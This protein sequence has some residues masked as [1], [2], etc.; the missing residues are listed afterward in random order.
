VTGFDV[1]PDD[2]DLCAASVDAG[3]DGVVKAVGLQRSTNDS[4]G[5]FWGTVHG[6]A[7]FGVEYQACADRVIGVADGLGPALGAVGDELRRQAGRYRGVDEH[8][9]AAFERLLGS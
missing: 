7:E 9:R 4:I 8:I 1:H 5:D 2:F 6:G 3:A